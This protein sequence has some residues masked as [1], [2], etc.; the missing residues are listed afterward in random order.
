MDR[1]LSGWGTLSSIR[2]SGSFLTLGSFHTLG[3]SLTLGNFVTLAMPLTCSLFITFHALHESL[4][5]LRRRL[6]MKPIF[7]LAKT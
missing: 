4:H 2:T 6:E 1:R 7:L 5:V 3:S